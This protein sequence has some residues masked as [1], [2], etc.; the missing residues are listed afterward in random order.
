VGK[1]T[2]ADYMKRNPALKRIAE[3]LE[4]AF[5]GVGEKIRGDL[6]KA[7]RKHAK[8][9]YDNFI[10]HIETESG[11][12]PR[13]RHGR[14]QFADWYRFANYSGGSHRP[15]HFWEDLREVLGNFSLTYKY[16][17]EDANRSYEHARDSFVY[18]NLGKMD[19]VLGKR[20]D[21]KNAVLRFDWRS[22]AF[23]G[24]VQ[25]Y[26]EGAYFRGEVS[27]KYV[28]RT[29]PRV[30]P[31]FQYPLVFTEAEVGGK[32]YARPSEQ[33]LR[34]L[35]SGKSS[36]QHEKEKAAQAAAEG[37]CPMS[38][39]EAKGVKVR[40]GSTAYV[41]CPSCKATVAVQ[42]YKYR[43][44]KTKAV[45]KAAEVRKLEDA[46]YCRMSGQPA[47][48]PLIEKFVRP[49]TVWPGGRE[50]IHYS[51]EIFDGMGK[52]RKILCEACGQNVVVGDSRDGLKPEEVRAI[53][54]KHKLTK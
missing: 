16:A 37:W 7:Y 47:P 5:N 32:L 38:G 19:E 49:H 28:I 54:R 14:Q 26:L 9:A 13:D 25:I 35:L 11:E 44:H 24:N 39:Q 33:E 31:Y 42:H 29:I 43:K 6:L 15:F 23:E 3:M 40:Y 22:G 27:I 50:E 8:G 30:T 34:N 1:L 4:N 21:L 12:I 18:K 20:S 52:Y 45:E 46:G 41:A 51:F 10:R 36:E 53:Y 2:V 48:Y 17:D